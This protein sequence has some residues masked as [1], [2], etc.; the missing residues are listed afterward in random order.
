MCGKYYNIQTIYLY[1]KKIV[2]LEQ[3]QSHDIVCAVKS[4]TEGNDR[5]RALKLISKSQYGYVFLVR[6]VV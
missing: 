6:R 2:S 5:H 1:T 3:R 4:G